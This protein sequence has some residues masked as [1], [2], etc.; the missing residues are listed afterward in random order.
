MQYKWAAAPC[1]EQKGQEMLKYW[2]DVQA[3]VLGYIRK[4]RARSGTI[5]LKEE[6]KSKKQARE[7]QGSSI[8]VTET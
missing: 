7:C 1:T 5:N 6:S 8:R 4:G 2:K 3:G